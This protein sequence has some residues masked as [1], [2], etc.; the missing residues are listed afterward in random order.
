MFYYLRYYSL[1]NDKCLYIFTASKL[2]KIII[3]DNNKYFIFPSNSK[4]F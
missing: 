1:R 2:S 4:I 3:I